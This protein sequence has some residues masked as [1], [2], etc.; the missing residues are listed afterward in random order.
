MEGVAD[1]VSGGDS[2]ENLADRG[3]FT[4]PGGGVVNTGSGESGETENY[5]RVFHMFVFH[6]NRRSVGQAA[7][8]VYSAGAYPQH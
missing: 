8:S 1:D 2:G 7:D 4:I 5:H 6:F 3:P